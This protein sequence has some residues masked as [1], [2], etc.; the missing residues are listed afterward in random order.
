M[1]SRTRFWVMGMLV[2]VVV[3][4]S[5]GVAASVAFGAF[6][7]EKFVAANC[8]EGHEE[9]V[10][11]ELGPY[12]PFSYFYSVPKEPTKAEAEVGGYTQ[13]AGHPAAGI[14]AFKINTVGA[15]PEAAPTG[16]VTHVRTDVA[17]GVSTNP[18]AVP[19][20]ERA[21]LGKEFAPGTNL[22]EAPECNANTK[23][24][25]NKA[26]VYL[27]PGG[28]PAGGDLPLTGNVYNME[29]PVGNSSSFG[30]ALPIP[31]FITEALLKVPTPQ[32]YAHTFIEGHI[33][34][35][36][37]YHDYYEIEVSPTLP[38]IASRLQLEGE[39][40]SEGKGGFITNPSNCSGPGPLTTNTVSLES[41]AGPATRTYTTP[42]APEGCVGEAGFIAPPFEPGF[43]VNPE[44]TQS[45][46][47]DGITT[48][49]SLPHDPSPSGI[50]SSQ[51]RNA[52]VVMPEGMTLNPSAG[53]G[54][55][56][57]TPAQFGMKTRN[58]MECPLG[59]RVGTVRLIV[60]DLP[61]SEPLEGNV[62]LGG[63]P[64]ITGPPYK[65]YVDAESARFGIS[66]RL[67]GTVTPNESTGRLTATFLENPEQPFTNIKLSFGVR[68]QALAPIANPLTCG[69][70][71]TET[72]FVPYTGGATKTPTS[73]FTVDS[74]GK[75]GACASPLP[76]ALTQS[77]EDHP[78][79]GG[80][81]PTSRSTSP[82]RRAA[83]SVERQ[84]RICRRDWSARSLPFRCARNRDATVGNCPAIEPDWRG[85]YGGRLGI[86]AR[87]L[88]RTGLSD[89]AQPARRP[90]RD[91][92]GRKRCRRPVQPRQ[93]GGTRADRSQPFT[94]R[95]TVAGKVP[96]IHAGIPL[97]L[98]AL[99]VA[100]NAPGLPDQPDQLRSA[101][102][103]IDDSARSRAARRRSQRPSRRPAA[104]RWRSSRASAPPRARRPRK[105][106]ARR[107][108]RN[109][110][111]T[112]K[113]WNRTSSR[114]W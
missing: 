18:T 73:V 57:C 43:A 97:R 41:N 90:V 81:R 32:L 70:A 50:D 95:V 22:F 93:R 104:A 11:E 44:T 71:L 35:A 56:A 112:R 14:T 27:G 98:K 20:C 89:G 51:L 68:G 77:T 85:R 19:N 55:V 8:K 38:L 48:E 75:G 1:T 47:P 79:G 52:T 65:L 37:D 62:Y 36:G 23:I 107:W 5:L 53:Q 60:P 102:H 61:A 83:V 7:V 49:V 46:A 113:G 59:S 111:S 67:E 100:I 45:D 92:D 54:L 80:R 9:C 91:D 29:T 96:T 114:W 6:G 40:G 58:T 74:D 15:F 10:E 105:P 21:K 31:K 63:G 110:T 101:G 28:P 109:S 24:G 16:I 4:A 42:I 66:T 72:S 84:R 87:Q 69:S 25:V 3:C 88:Q 94:G 99:S 30:V 76:F 33:E 86:D 64:T 103:R 106:T 2:G 26:I 34:W 39:L 82:A 108:S 12:G 17:P 78:T 13:A